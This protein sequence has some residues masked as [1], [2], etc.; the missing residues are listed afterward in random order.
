MVSW[1][2]AGRRMSLG[3]FKDD[4]DKAMLDVNLPNDIL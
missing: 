2:S 1:A 3:V 4:K